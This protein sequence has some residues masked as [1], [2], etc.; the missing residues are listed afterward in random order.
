MAAT[1]QQRLHD[2]GA[3][4]TGVR[5]QQVGQ[6]VGGTLGAGDGLGF[7]A[8]TE[9]IRRRR[10]QGFQQQGRVHPP[11]QR[12]VAHRQRA[13]RLAVVAAGQRHE[14]GAPFDAA[15]VE[16]VEGHLQRHF[17]ARRAV[18]GVEHLGQRRAAAAFINFAARGE[19]QQ[20]FGQFHRRCVRAAGQDHLFQRA[21]LPADGRGDAGLGVAVQVGPP[22]ADAVE[23]APSVEPHQPRALAALHR[24]Q[25]QGMRMLA[26]LRAGMPE[27]GQVAC[28]PVI[29]GGYHGSIVNAF[30]SAIIAAGTAA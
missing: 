26:H 14:F 27:H 12:D 25:R 23:D 21:G 1:L 2:Q 15:V 20:A 3:D 30:H 28:P 9:G 24:K 29:R 8:R 22:A 10:E 17:H 16:P 18:V 11:V 13:Q 19:G 4:L 5:V 6:G 7:V